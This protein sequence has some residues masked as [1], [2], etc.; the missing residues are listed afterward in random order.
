M[1]DSVEVLEAQMKIRIDRRRFLLGLASLGAAVTL[2]AKP[3][4]LHIDQVWEQ[5]GDTPWFFEVSESNTIVEPDVAAPQVR[6]DIYDISVAGLR[7]PADIVREV[8]QYDEL[9]SHFAGLSS[10]ELVEVVDALHDEDLAPDERRRLE[11]L[12]ELLED[13]D[14]GWRDWVEAEGVN[15][16]ERFRD[17][18]ESWLDDD[19]DWSQM[20]FWPP[21]W[22]GQDRA[23]AWRFQDRSAT[24]GLLD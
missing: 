1:P 19:L 11:A 24:P 10:D 2:P 21:G 5:W 13:E 7:T 18:I 8:G 17:E 20:E 23:L 16:L 9:R 12:Q 22:N 3:T 4:S 14:E 6:R 15:G